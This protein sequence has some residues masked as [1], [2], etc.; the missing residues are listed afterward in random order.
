MKIALGFLGAIL[1]AVAGVLYLA[2]MVSNFVQGAQTFASPDEAMNMHNLVYLMTGFAIMVV[3]WLI[4]LM[5]GGA[6]ENA[7]ERRNG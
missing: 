5:V 7:K 1:G 3:G 6:I 4:G 2:P